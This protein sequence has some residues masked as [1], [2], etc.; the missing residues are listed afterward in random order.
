MLFTCSLVHL[1][2]WQPSFFFLKYHCYPFAPPIGS[3]F[4]DY[5]LCPLL[6]VQTS[7]ISREYLPAFTP[8]TLHFTPYSTG[9]LGARVALCSGCRRASPLR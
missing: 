2:I 4:S 8:Y 9:R 7:A 1:F 6:V 5:L 3:D